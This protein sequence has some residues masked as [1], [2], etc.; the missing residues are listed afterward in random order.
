MTE[1]PDRAAF[2]AERR[3][4]RNLKKH[5]R[6]VTDAVTRFMTALDAEMEKPST[7]ERGGRIASLT[8]ELNMHNDMARR[9]G[10]DE[11]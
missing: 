11:K 9:Y 4:S 10:L 6:N 7:R 8:N 3:R 2:I 1:N 5:L